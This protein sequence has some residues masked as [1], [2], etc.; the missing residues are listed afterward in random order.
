MTTAEETELLIATRRD[1]HRHPEIGFQEFRTAGIV[2]ERLR[3]A[4]YEVRTGIAETGVV[5]TLHGGAGDGRT[6][7]LRA[8]MDALPVD[9][10]TTHDFRST[11]AGTM[12]ACGHDAHVAVGLAVAERLA[13]TR[14][15]WAGTVKYMFQPAEEG[16]G[17]A[18]GMI[19]AGVLDGV[20]AALG[21]HVW[22]GL[23]SGV[24]GVVPGPQ[25]AGAL[26]FSVTIK[27]RGGHGA[28]PHETV[29]ALHTAAQVIVALQSIV[30]RTVPPLEPAVVTVASMHAGSAHNVIAETASLLGTMRAFDPALLAELPKRAERVIAGVC[31]AMGAEYEFHHRMEAVPTVNDPAL[32]ELVRR[33]AVAIVGADRVRTDPDVRTMAAE[34]FGDVLAKVPGCYFFVGGR[35]E[36]RGMTHPHHSP[37]FDLCE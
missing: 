2:A 7:L 16:L 37:R 5:G 31:A 11:V 10:E 36:E 23:E 27:G 20:D 14:G 15:E 28:M 32:A 3:A 34:D 21:L 24:V 12:H 19:D 29:D 13:R 33:E 25:M 4:G 26:E 9:E 17:G 18:L 22:L 30:S 8:D 35:N 1:L 6:L